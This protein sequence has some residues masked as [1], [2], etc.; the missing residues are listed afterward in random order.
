M[1]WKVW[2]RVSSVVRVRG[3]LGL[4]GETPVKLGNPKLFQQKALSFHKEFSF[5]KKDDPARPT[6]DIDVSLIT[7]LPKVSE[8]RKHFEGITTSLSDW[9]MNRKERIARRLEGI[10]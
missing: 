7:S 10:E 5:E 6:R 4:G 8:L 1:E 3:C 9:E 2:G